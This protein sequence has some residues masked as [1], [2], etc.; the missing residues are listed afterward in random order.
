[1]KFDQDTLKAIETVAAQMQAAGIRKLAI[2]KLAWLTLQQ[3]RH[4]LIRRKKLTA[5]EVAI[6]R[7][8]SA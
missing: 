8:R 3:P 1:M 5:R 7:F 2:G 6:R 4:P